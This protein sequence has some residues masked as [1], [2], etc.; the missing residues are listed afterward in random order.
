MSDSGTDGTTITGG[1]MCGGVRW[2]LS[3]RP[4]GAG[5]CHCRRCQRRTGTAFS[6]T[7][8][9][10]PG[11]FSLTAG[12]ELLSSWSAGDGWTKHFCGRCGSQVMTTNPED[13]DGIG[14]RLGGFD[15]D[16]GVEVFFHQFTAYAPAWAP[17][18]DDGL[19]RYPERIDSSYAEAAAEAGRK[20]ADNG[21][22]ESG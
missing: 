13:P 11:S 10:A 2:R 1:C 19:P 14:L 9:A 8:L 16:P 20:A 22:P 15:E 6:L 3:E 7:A 18:A 17:V 4:L 5:C 12:D 21:T